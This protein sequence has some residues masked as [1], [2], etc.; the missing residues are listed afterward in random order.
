M[1]S[2]LQPVMAFEQNS[3]IIKC[4]QLYI[5][6]SEARFKLAC[7]FCW[8]TYHAYVQHLLL[9]IRALRLRSQSSIYT[10]ICCVCAHACL[11]QKGMHI[12]AALS[13]GMQQ[14][15][16]LNMY[17]PTWTTRRLDPMYHQNPA[18]VEE[19]LSCCLTPRTHAA[20]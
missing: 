5:T 1:H 2:L 17:H 6:G 3:C 12:P 9:H 7:C 18:E 19:C 14:R 10:H 20:T 13:S 4:A 15:V 8:Q 16:R 11:G